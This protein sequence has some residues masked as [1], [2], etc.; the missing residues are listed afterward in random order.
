[1]LSQPAAT[2]PIDEL[3]FMNE[4]FFRAEESIMGWNPCCLYVPT[5]KI[6]I[7]VT[8]GCLRYLAI[9]EQKV[10]TLL[11]LKIL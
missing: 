8:N 2:N 4:N 9:L 5:N 3:N 11:T 7:I 6:N 10:A 1:M